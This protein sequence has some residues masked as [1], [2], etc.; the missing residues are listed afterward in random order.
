MSLQ[1]PT[2]R[3]A[4]LSLA[5]YVQGTSSLAG[6][7]RVFK[8]SSNENPLGASPLALEAY[9]E[10][11]KKL[12]LYPDGSA[13]A[14]RACL[15]HAHG[16]E[17]ERL[18]CGSG[19]DELLHLLASAFLQ[20]GDEALYSQ[21]G[22]LVYPIAI[23]AAGAKAIAIPEKDLAADLDAILAAVNERT[24]LIFL[25]NPNNPTGTYVSF[26]RLRAFHEA[27]PAHLLLVLDAAYAEYVTAPDYDAC[28]GLAREAQNV[29]VTRTFS[30]IYGLANARL[31][32]AYGPSP[33][34]DVL[35]RLRGPFNVSGPAMA[36][37]VAA[38]L[39]ENHVQASRAHNTRWRD[40]LFQ[41]LLGYG[42]R[43]TPSQGNFLLV[44][45]GAQAGRDAPDLDQYLQQ[46]GLIVRRMESYGLPHA[47]R[48]SVGSDEANTH[49]LDV[50]S[51]WAKQG[52]V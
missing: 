37:G 19:S 1:R 42:F 22:F 52:A 9:V 16:L 5:P 40:V 24:K 13:F 46:H 3:D 17:A 2:P 31:G 36:A 33:V 51:A 45:T 41:S 44:H 7:M 30:K 35:N 47:L 11:A 18:V 20:P 27:L 49:L 50:L 32:W 28:Y 21:H 6:S 48:I 38:T 8:L 29:V 43:V 15:A 10:E 23:Q 4:V 25:A 34:I 12:D 39:D 14:L 26:E